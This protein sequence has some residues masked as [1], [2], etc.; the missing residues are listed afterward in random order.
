MGLMILTTCIRSILWHRRM[1]RHA[2]PQPKPRSGAP[3]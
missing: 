3:A 2:V 1:L